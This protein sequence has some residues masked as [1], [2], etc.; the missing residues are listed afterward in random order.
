MLYDVN[1]H[2]LQE[3]I[4][5]EIGLLLADTIKHLKSISNK[6]NIEASSLAIQYRDCYDEIMSRTFA[7]KERL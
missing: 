4:N 6:Y 1:N 7:Q 3:E 5:G 2:P